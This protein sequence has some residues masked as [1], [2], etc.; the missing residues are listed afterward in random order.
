MPGRVRDE[1]AKGRKGERKGR[2]TEAEKARERKDNIREKIGPGW[3]IPL[4]R[5]P[6]RYTKAV[7]LSSGQ[8]THKKQL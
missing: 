7:G 4:V 8:D 2:S 1:R 6:S 3:V 5:A